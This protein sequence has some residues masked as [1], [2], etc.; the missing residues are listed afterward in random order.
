MGGCLKDGVREVS[1]VQIEGTRRKQIGNRSSVS[2]KV[3]WRFRGQ[4][5][6]WI[7]VRKSNPFALRSEERI[8]AGVHQAWTLVQQHQYHQELVR[9]A[10]FAFHPRSTALKTQGEGS[11][12]CFHKPCRWFQCIWSL[13]THELGNSWRGEDP[14]D[15]T[16]QCLRQGHRLSVRVASR[17]SAGWRCREGGLG[18]LLRVDAQES[19]RD[20]CKDCQSTRCHKKVNVIQ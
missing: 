5:V 7:Q 12:P 1:M 8:R 4:M 19:G 15:K 11:S 16:M 3:G 18:H 17:V 14:S 10:T 9:N 6:Q 13:R 20:L 2:E